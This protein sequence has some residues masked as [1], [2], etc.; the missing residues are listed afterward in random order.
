MLGSKMDPLDVIGKVVHG[1][2]PMSTYLDSVYG[3]SP[4]LRG[5]ED[6]HY[7][8]AAEV[9]PEK[10]GSGVGAGAGAGGFELTS[11]DVPVLCT[12]K[13]TPF[14]TPRTA[15]PDMTEGV[16]WNIFQ[17]IWNTNYPFW[18]PFVKG[19]S[20][21]QFRFGLRVQVQVLAAGG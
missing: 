19:D 16:S 10:G 20:S 14:V 15:P 12:G 11:L 9:R 1:S 2:N 5:V 6:A 7:T 3:G 13:A 21:A 18:Y 17:N 8:S 4:H